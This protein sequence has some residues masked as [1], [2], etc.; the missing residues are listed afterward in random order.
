MMRLHPR[1]QARCGFTLIEVIIVIAL[2]AMLASLGW[3][4]VSKVRNS[5][6]NKTAEIQ[7]GQ[8]EM[9]M[10][11]YRQD[12]GD[13]LP[14]GNGDAW[15]AHVLYATLSCDADNDGQPDIDPKTDEVKV[16]YCEIA[17]IANLKHVKDQ[18]NGLIATKLPIKVPNSAKSGKQ[19]RFVIL[20][21]W[22]NP[23]R[24]RLGYEM[25]DD[26]HKEGPGLNPDFD[27]FSQGPDGEGN[28]LT[29]SGNNED[30]I[31]NIKSWN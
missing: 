13:V 26:K 24:Y 5:E 10:N 4:A 14:A 19:K 11:N 1:P 3:V 8:L 21:P 23:Y 18:P 6:M 7:I 15:S 29:N 12:Y 25:R 20:D 17:A 30:N 31:S 27:I 28:G 9:G 2:M 16:P 22:G